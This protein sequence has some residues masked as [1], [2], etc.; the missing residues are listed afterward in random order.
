MGDQCWEAKQRQGR[1][2]QHWHHK[3]N[4][5]LLKP[6]SGTHAQFLHPSSPLHFAAKKKK[7]SKAKGFPHARLTPHQPAE[8]LISAE[9]TAAASA[10]NTEDH[11]VLV[12][13]LRV[14][15]HLPLSFCSP[16]HHCSLPLMFLLFL[17]PSVLPHL[18]FSPLFPLLCTAPLCTAPVLPHSQGGITRQKCRHGKERGREDEENKKKK[19][20]GS[21]FVC[22]RS[23]TVLVADEI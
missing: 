3:Q 17:S 6:Q 21:P 14:F 22:R 23:V 9:V 8:G 11:T 2:A 15:R 10:S 19:L 12:L 5:S 20:A 16:S 13:T 1:K 4:V 7:K 18:S